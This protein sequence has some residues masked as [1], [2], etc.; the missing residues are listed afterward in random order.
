[1]RDRFWLRFCSFC[2][3]LVYCFVLGVY[4][5]S[6][7]CGGV[8]ACSFFRSFRVGMLNFN[9]LAKFWSKKTTK[10]Y[11]DIFPCSFFYI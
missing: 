7:Y 2:S 8:A 9:F 3:F 4:A 11:T 6:F 10:N 5:C 1:M